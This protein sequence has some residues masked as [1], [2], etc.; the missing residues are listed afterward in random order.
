MSII[1]RLIG[2][3]FLSAGIVGLMYTTDLLDGITVPAQVAFKMYPMSTAP[4]DEKISDYLKSRLESA[5]PD[6]RIPVIIE[7]TAPTRS[8]TGKITG[9]LAMAQQAE[10]IPK[11]QA[12]DFN[13]QIAT[14]YVANMLAGTVPAKYV[15]EIARD[16]NVKAIYLDKYQWKL[17]EDVDEK[18]Y[19]KLLRESVPMIGVPDVWDEGYTGKG[20][21]VIIIDSGVMDSHPWLIRNGKSLVLTE[22]DIAPGVDYTHWHGTHC[23]GI[24]ASQDPT[25]RG[26]APD[27]EGFVDILA[28]DN[29]GGATDSWIISALDTAYQVAVEYKQQGYAVVATNS[30]GG[31]AQDN[32]TVNKMREMVMNIADEIPIVFAAGNEGPSPS[33]IGAPGDADRGDNEAITVCAVNKYGTIAS[34]SSRGPDKYGEDHNEP[35]ICAPGVGIMS[36][37]PGGMNTASGTSMATPHIAGV[38][39]LMLQKNPTLTNMQVF[40]YLT[41]TAIDA[42]DPGFDFDYGYGIVDTKAA[43]DAVPEAP[44]PSSP[45]ASGEIVIGA[46]QLVSVI[47]II[48][49]L[50]MTLK[51]DE[52]AGG[53]GL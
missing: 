8:F 31:P 25:Y 9:A 39:A 18:M 38:I 33:T 37:V 36:S 1:V 27:I 16:P 14:H 50:A 52:F 42:G 21:V 53:V 10:V 13:L 6:E 46:V 2:I 45:A 23:A 29:R 41:S 44:L 28:F 30:W 24:I 3:L 12:Y 32:P 4:P 11:L 35:D 26:V 51:P 34:F 15:E 48:F 43:V 40:E 7:L 5:H 17:T 47:L 20:V 22:Y 19:V 49:G